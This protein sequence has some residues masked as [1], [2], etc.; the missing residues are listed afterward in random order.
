VFGRVLEDHAHTVDFEILDGSFTK[1]VARSAPS[2]QL[3]G[4]AEALAYIGRTDYRPGA[5]RTGRTAVGSWRFRRR[6]FPN[7]EVHE[8]DG[9]EEGD[10]ADL[11]SASSTMR[12]PTQW[13]P[14]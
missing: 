10:L 8:V 9:S 5:T 3:H 14:A 1:R 7:R 6:H 12:Y 13:S 4:L 11:T 2:R